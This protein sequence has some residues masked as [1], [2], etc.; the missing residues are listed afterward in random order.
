MT[1]IEKPR[2]MGKASAEYRRWMSECAANSKPDRL[3]VTSHIYPPIPIRDYDWMAWF[4]ENEEGP[5]GFGKT[6]AEAKA[7]LL[8]NYGDDV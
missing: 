2:D 8:D 7:D 4:D 5:Q 3:I 6:E 1:M